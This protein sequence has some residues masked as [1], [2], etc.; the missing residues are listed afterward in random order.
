MENNLLFQFESEE[1]HTL[2]TIAASVLS[3]ELVTDL[4]LEI[5]QGHVDLPY[6]VFYSREHLFVEESVW[7]EFTELLEE[8]HAAGGCVIF[9]N[10]G[11]AAA[12][13]AGNPLLQEAEEIQEAIDELILYQLDEELE[14]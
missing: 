7:P 5:H 2:V 6:F 14:E 9:V 12:F 11:F 8:I 4:S 13:K 1:T 3:Q 10:F